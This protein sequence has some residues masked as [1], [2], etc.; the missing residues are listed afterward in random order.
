[1]VFEDLVNEIPSTVKAASV[2]ASFCLEPFV[3]VLSIV[4]K[5][6]PD[7]L[8]VAVT[9]SAFSFPSCDFST[10]VKVSSPAPKTLAVTP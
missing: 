4:D 10:S 6:D 7:G 2:P 8:S 5:P 1:M 3:V 9:L